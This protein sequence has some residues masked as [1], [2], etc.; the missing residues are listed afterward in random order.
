MGLFVANGERKA[1]GEAAR[2]EADEGVKATNKG[3]D[4]SS[5]CGMGPRTDVEHQRYV[6]TFF[7]A[8]IPRTERL[9]LEIFDAIQTCLRLPIYSNK[10]K[11]EMEL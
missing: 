11:G 3:T 10:F 4:K 6:M 7:R 1:M 5:K 2:L 8:R 9:L